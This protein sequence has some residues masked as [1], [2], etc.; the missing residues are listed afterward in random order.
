MREGDEPGAITKRG[1]MRFRTLLIQ[2]A[3]STVMTAARRAGR[4]SHW[5]PES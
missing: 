5:V 1:D 2:A 3:K 4:I